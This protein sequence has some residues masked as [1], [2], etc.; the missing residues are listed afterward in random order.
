L[1]NRA[2]VLAL[3]SMNIKLFVLCLLTVLT[4]LLTGCVETLDG[5]TEP[6]V[7]FFKDKVEGRYERSLAQ[8]LDASRAVI[9]FNGQL[10]SDNVV[11]NS[12]EGRIDQMWVFVKVDEIDGGAGGKSLTRVTVQARNKFG[13]TNVDLA[14]EIEKQIAI[15][16]ATR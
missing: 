2:V 15:Q 3:L 16:L 6:G 10:I 12:L 4:G 14:H 8:V 5:H 13:G 11:N 7:P 1:T 9:K